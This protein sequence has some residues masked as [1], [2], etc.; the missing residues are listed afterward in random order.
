MRLSLPRYLTHPGLRQ[1]AEILISILATTDATFLPRRENTILSARRRWFAKRG[2]PWTPWLV[3]PVECECHGNL[4]LSLGRLIADGFVVERDSIIGPY[5]TIGL[6]LTNVGEEVCRRLLGQPGLA[7]ALSMCRVLWEHI[8]LGGNK[9]I[10]VTDGEDVLLPAL[11]RGLFECRVTH[12]GLEPEPHIRYRL[13]SH[14]ESELACPELQQVR[15]DDR[16]QDF[17]HWRFSEEQ[18]WLDEENRDWKEWMPEDRDPW[19]SWMNEDSWVLQHM[20]FGKRQCTVAPVEF[21]DAP[22]DDFV[23]SS[24]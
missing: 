1:E 23:G 10:N 13:L 16:A 22:E 4:R 9:W 3:E 14:A 20:L 12:R 18:E 19:G 21:E 11:I 17:Y 15:P 6:A 7:D 24:A 5:G 2:V 8:A